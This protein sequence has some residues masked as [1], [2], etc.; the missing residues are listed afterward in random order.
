MCEN[1]LLS[2][3]RVKSKEVKIM[4]TQELYEFMK[5]NFDNIQRQFEDVNKRLGTL[6]T[7]VA[8]IKGKLEGTQ[9]GKA[10][11]WQI[12]TTATAVGAV[13]IAL[14]ALLK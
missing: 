6:E 8:W 12:V 5:Q 11:V 9:E 10:S 7:D 3:V 14:V 4:T 2:H 13:I 1:P